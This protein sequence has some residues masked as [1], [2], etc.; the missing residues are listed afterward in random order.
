[1]KK[2]LLAAVVSLACISL[3]VQAEIR[4]NG[5]ASIVAGQTLDDNTTLYGYDDDISY[6]NESMFALQLSSDL[7][8]RLSA[9]A[10]IVARGNEDFDAE[11]EWAYVSYQINDD[12]KV[13]GGKMRIPFYRY[14]DFLDVGYA[15]RWVRPPQSVYNF[16]FST[17]EGLNLLHST[18]L[19]D[20]DSTTQLIY[21][22]FSGRVPSAAGAT[23]EQVELND[24]A[25]INWTI[26][27]DW[28]S[29]RAAYIVAETT[30]SASSVVGL[31]AALNG[32]GLNNQANSLLISEDDGAFFGLGFS[33]DYDNFLFDAE[34]T[35]IEVENS[36]LP[37]QTQYYA[38]VGYRIDDWTVHLT[39]ENN[40]DEHD[41]NRL[42]TVPASIS[43]PN[44]TVIPVSLDPTNANSPL[45][46]DVTNQ[47]LLGAKQES[48][49]VSVGARYDFHPSAALKV[50]LSRYNDDITDQD[51]D[52][53]AVAIDLVF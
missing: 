24:L 14:S 11:F 19:G 8:D 38:S 4:I 49:T 15:Y 42:N 29:A 39:Y 35:E 26:S 25:G 50:D 16:A 28:F 5:F 51:I 13:S 47:V 12:L 48:S 33:I 41:S 30:I 23:P 9:T 46:R 1:M 10:Q 21:G 17:Y 53:L 43:G 52:V 27:Y 31:T 6:K 37:D 22:S 7:Q 45:L 18:T 3:N 36:L 20:W 32:Y 40:D 44:G 2:R 34:Y